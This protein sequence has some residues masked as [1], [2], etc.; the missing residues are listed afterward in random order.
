MIAEYYEVLARPK[1]SRFLDFFN[2][3]EALLA[4]IESKATKYVPKITLDLIS[5]ADDN[6]ILELADECVA[7]F[8]IT[9]NTNDFIFPEYKQTKIVSPKEYWELHQPR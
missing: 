3:A 1:F 8:V 2:R 6:M 5:D 4:E 7:D 9:G